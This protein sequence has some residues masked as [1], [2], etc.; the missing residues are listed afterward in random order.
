MTRLSPYSFTFTDGR[1]ATFYAPTYSQ[2]LELA[3]TWSRARGLELEATYADALGQ[4]AV[5]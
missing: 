2:A 4:K 1:E 3:L 5:A